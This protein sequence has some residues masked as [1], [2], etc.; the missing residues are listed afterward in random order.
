MTAPFIPMLFQ[1]EEWGASTPFLY[2][3]DHKDPALGRAVTDGRRREFAAFCAHVEDVPDPQAAETFERSRL[4]WREC[5]KDPHDDLLEWH[6]QLIRLRRKNS[7][8]SDGRLEHVEVSFDE[9]AQWIVMKRRTAAVACNLAAGM[10]HVPLQLGV[11]EV[12]LA[13]NREAR[14]TDDGID[15]PSESVAVLVATAGTAGQVKR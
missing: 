3:T 9:K 15:L 6:R 13:S 4:N 2:F 14:L 1:G 7:D 10:Q 8:L 5:E 11:A 12:L